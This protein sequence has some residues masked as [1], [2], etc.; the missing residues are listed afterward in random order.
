MV[1]CEYWTNSSSVISVIRWT[2]IGISMASLLL[3]NIALG[4]PIPDLPK[5][6]GGLLP[7]NKITNLL[8]E[9]V[10]DKN[11][12]KQAKKNPVQYLRERGIDVAE[13]TSIYLLDKP[14]PPVPPPPDHWFGIIGWRVIKYCKPDEDSHV[15]RCEDINVPIIKR[16]LQPR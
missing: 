10:K 12:W 8:Q 16:T 3:V 13:G 15:M 14:I 2:A 11:L 6:R 9:T 5:E 7:D 4:Q 1:R